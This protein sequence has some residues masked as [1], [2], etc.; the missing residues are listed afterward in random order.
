MG[1][2]RG[3][4]LP[5]SSIGVCVWACVLVGVCAYVRVACACAIHDTTPLDIQIPQSLITACTKSPLQSS[6]LTSAIGTISPT[7]EQF[8]VQ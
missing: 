7:V 6:Q 4:V 5:K 1:R 3:R 8:I 2:L